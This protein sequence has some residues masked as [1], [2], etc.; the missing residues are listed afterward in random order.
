MWADRKQVSYLL[1]GKEWMPA[2]EVEHLVLLPDASVRLALA[3]PRHLGMTTTARDS[4]VVQQGA[5]LL[6]VQQP[7]W[8][9]L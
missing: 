3:A 5:H 9:G 4:D 6:P 2:E 8:W 1:H 7:D